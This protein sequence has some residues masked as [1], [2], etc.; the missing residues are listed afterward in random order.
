[1]KFNFFSKN[2]K[3][4]PID[5][6]TI[7]LLSIEYAYGFGVYETLRVNN[8]KV[9]FLED[10]I[11]RLF[12]SA[13]IIKLEHPFTKENIKK[14]IEELAVET[15]T[16]TYNVK[17]L[18]IGAIKSE[19]TNLYIFC[20]TPLFTDKKLY[21]DGVKTI[22][23]DYE[24]VYP[25]AKTLNMLQSYLAYREAK[26]ENCYDAL[27][28]NKKGNITE[29]TRTNFLVIKDNTIYS[30]LE[31]DIL[32]GVTRKHVLDV[33]KKNGFVIKKR[34]I[35]KNSLDKYD[36]AFLTSTSAKILPIKKIDNLEYK[37]IP[38]SVFR[39]MNLF[40]KFINQHAI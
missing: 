22:T 6:A 26:S 12:K 16:E 29:G 23:T 36:G 33:A 34:N 37:K 5:E 10:H 8:S 28:V 19:E 2:G 25:Q 3:I 39:L 1:M 31:E 7:S 4:L 17:M 9:L 40:D 18:L 38:D 24:R 14:Y 15:E 21:R 13:E 11:E 27:L 30:P 32:L 20:S 35:S